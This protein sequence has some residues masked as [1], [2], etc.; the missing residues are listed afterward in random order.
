ML[1]W[2]LAKWDNIGRKNG[3][4]EGWQIS[5]LLLMNFEGINGGIIP[6]KISILP[7][8]KIFGGN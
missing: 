8:K 2:S 5:S 7:Y 6:L 3:N 1:G 4:E